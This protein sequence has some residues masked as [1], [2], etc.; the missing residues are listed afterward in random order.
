MSLSVSIDR[1]KYSMRTKKSKLENRNKKLIKR[2]LL[3]SL[4][5]LIKLMRLGYESPI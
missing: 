1:S 4:M 2:I 5:T 3:R